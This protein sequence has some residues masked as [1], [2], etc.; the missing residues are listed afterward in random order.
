MTRMETEVPRY[1]YHFIKPPR[2]TEAVTS[3]GKSNLSSSAHDKVERG[4]DSDSDADSNI[5]LTEE[6]E[7]LLASRPLHGTQSDD[8]EICFEEYIDPETPTYDPY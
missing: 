3:D 2:T 4:G 5:T 6:D 7:T 1:E 8:D